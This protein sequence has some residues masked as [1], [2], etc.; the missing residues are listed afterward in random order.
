MLLL[1]V[2]ARVVVVVVV[3]GAAVGS[4]ASIMLSYDGCDCCCGAPVLPSLGIMDARR[5]ALQAR[6]MAPLR[7]TCDCGG[8]GVFVY[9]GWSAACVTCL[10]RVG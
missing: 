2:P 10:W 9:V 4:A 1:L 8:V 3:P 7:S 5:R 6:G